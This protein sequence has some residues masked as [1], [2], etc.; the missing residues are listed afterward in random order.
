MTI[1]AKELAQRL[2][3]SATAVSMALNNRPGVSTE[4]R[5]RVLKAAEQY[6]YDFSKLSSKNRR[7]GD[8]Y[9]II[10]RAHNALLNYAP[11]FSELT[12]GIE[13]ECR[14]QNFKIKIIQFNENIDDIKKLIEDIRISNCAGIILLGTETSINACSLFM[15]LSIPLVLLDSYFDSL[16]CTSILINNSQGA[17][18]ATNFLIDRCGDHP[19]YLKSSY[20]IRNF[21]DR[22]NGFIK[23]VREHG[24]SATSTITHNLSPSIEGS[25]SDMLEIIDNGD[26]LARCYFA[27]NDLIA[28]GTIKALKLRGY[29][30]PEDIAIVG[31]DN[32]SES[33]IVEP[34]LTTIDIPRKYMGQEA[35]R[36]LINKINNPVPYA[37]K[38]EVATKLIKR[39][40]V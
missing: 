16:Y 12:D 5:N 20:R 35:T 30:I 8:I 22:K 36:Q 40:S 26:T 23:A 32:I 7:S 25:F 19:G 1:T 24:M 14:N 27:D 17:Y 6:N 11:I 9:C 15:Q 33:R 28:I 37:V 38:I 3:L 10:Y 13:Q 39:F 29:R 31:F 2:G 21:D 4:T 18:L 34:S